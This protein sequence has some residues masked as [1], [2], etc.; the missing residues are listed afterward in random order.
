MSPYLLYHY[1][2]IRWI[3][4]GCISLFKEL[5]VSKTI[6]SSIMILYDH[7]EHILAGFRE[8]RKKVLYN[9]NLL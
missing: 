6:R 4:S 3:V 8:Q 5:S 2:M 7:W 9:V 1:I